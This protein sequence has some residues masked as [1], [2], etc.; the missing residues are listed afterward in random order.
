MVSSSKRAVIAILLALAL[1]DIWAY[2]AIAQASLPLPP[3]PLLQG[4]PELPSADPSSGEIQ[5]IESTTPAQQNATTGT[6]ENQLQP[7]AQPAIDA[8]QQ[9]QPAPPTA[10]E[11]LSRIDRLD[12]K[13]ANLE[14]QI[15]LIPNHRYPE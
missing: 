8:L 2:S 13:V 7:F 1:L 10:I 14:E 11:L 6:A 9:G 4:L 12:N 5:P 3:P 15:R